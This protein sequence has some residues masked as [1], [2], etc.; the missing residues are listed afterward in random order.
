MGIIK[1]HPQVGYDILKEIEFSWPI[2]QTVYQHHERMDGS[3]YPRALCGEDI[4]MEARILAVADVV[5]AMSSL[6]PYRLPPGI[7]A[8]LAEI[9]QKKGTLYDSGV[10]EACLS[11]FHKKIFD[12]KRKPARTKPNDKSG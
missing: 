10:V 7:D 9:S 8:A 3:G 2:A 6:R 11:C 1:T 5:E 4:L 12:F